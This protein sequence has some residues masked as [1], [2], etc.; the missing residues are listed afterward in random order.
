MDFNCL[1]SNFLSLFMRGLGGSGKDFAHEL[2]ELGIA[3]HEL[4]DSFPDR[5]VQALQGPDGLERDARVGLVSLEDLYDDL[6]GL[7][8]P[9]PCLVSGLK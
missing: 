6:D 3:W 7:D 4:A 2:R 8:V 9:C 1:L 5:G